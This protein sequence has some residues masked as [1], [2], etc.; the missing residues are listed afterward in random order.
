MKGYL[1]PRNSS[2]AIDKAKYEAFKSQCIKITSLCAL[3]VLNDL[4]DVTDEDMQ[5]WYDEYEKLIASIFHG[6]DDLDKIEQALVKQCKIQ[7]EER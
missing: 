2:K 3:A 7:F 1:R 5:T 6:T 4:W